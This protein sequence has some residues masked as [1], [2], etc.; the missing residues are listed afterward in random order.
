M[1]GP[2]ADTVLEKVLGSPVYTVCTWE[3]L[4][5]K[6]M[7]R[8]PMQRCNGSTQNKSGLSHL[9]AGNLVAS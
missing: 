9:L 1:F 6:L 7:Y 8:L 3:R 2:V 4:G 5:T